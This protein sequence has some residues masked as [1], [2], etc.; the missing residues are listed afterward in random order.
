LFNS[1]LCKVGSVVCDL[2]PL[3]KALELRQPDCI[4]DRENKIM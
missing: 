1:E 4:I 2:I 3:L